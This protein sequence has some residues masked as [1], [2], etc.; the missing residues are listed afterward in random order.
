LLTEAQ[1]FLGSD[2][3]RGAALVREHVVGAAVITRFY[4]ANG[5]L[6]GSHTTN[7]SLGP[8]NVPTWKD[9]NGNIIEKKIPPAVQ[10][11]ARDLQTRLGGEYLVMVTRSPE[12]IYPPRYLVSVLYSPKVLREGQFRS[13]VIKINTNGSFVGVQETVF[14][15][16]KNVD[17]RLLY[18][19]LLQITSDPA[20]LLATGIKIRSAETNSITFDHKDYVWEIRRD[21]NG[22]VILEK[23]LPIVIQNVVDSLREQFGP[24]FGITVTA[25]KC[26][27]GEKC[28]GA[29][30]IQ[31]TYLPKV[32]RIGQLRSVSLT[33]GAKGD[34]RGVSNVHFDGMENL[35]G[36]MLYQALHQ[37]P[38]M[39]GRLPMQPLDP[40]VVHL[41]ALRTM[42][43]L[44]VNDVETN[45]AIHFQ[46]AGEAFRAYR[47]SDGKVILERELPLAVREYMN[48]LQTRLGDGFKVTAARQAD[49]SYLISVV[50]SKVY[51]KTPTEGLHQMRFVIRG[52]DLCTQGP[53]GKCTTTGCV[54]V[55]ES[56]QA[57]FYSPKGD[58]KVDGQ[59]LFEAMG[60]CPQGQVCTMHL[61]DD[62][63]KLAKLAR[64]AVSSVDPDGAIHFQL[65]GQNY[66]T[67]RDKNGN[68]VLEFENKL[69]PAVQAYIKNLQ[70][71]LGDGFSVTAL[72]QK[73]GTYQV[74]ILR[75]I[76]KP[77][78]GSFTSATF[79]LTS[80]GA[81]KTESIKVVYAGKEVDASLL[82]AGLQ[83]IPVIH[84]MIA[85]QVGSYCP[86]WNGLALLDRLSS[87]RIVETGKNLVRFDLDGQGY[88]AYRDVAGK[89]ILEK[90]LPLAVQAHVKDLQAQLGDGFIV[91]ATIQKD[92][93]YLI[94]VVDSKV[95]IRTPTAGL[96][97]MSYVLRE[98]SVCRQG[99]GG[100]CTSAGWSVDSKSLSAVYYAKGG[101]I[102]IKDSE[103]LFVAMG[104]CPQ[105][106]VCTVRVKGDLERLEKMSKITVSSVDSTGAIFYSL[107]GTYYKAYRD[108][109][110]NAR[111]IVIK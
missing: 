16:I 104:M 2:V 17:A 44:T 29:Y 106:Q 7:P 82:V 23:K 57:S 32:L 56:I 34:I 87:L 15:G 92:G 95:Y 50:D 77:T 24:A 93:T 46:L 83:Q 103:L 37:L 18:D 3:V 55:P 73:D 13:M 14:D 90:E 72:L 11:Y 52:L 30:S 35:D 110:G 101:D 68:V 45:G 67:F 60:A 85:C 25:I 49:G 48:D 41:Q 66:K 97:E 19:G 65:E 79:S 64:V 69:P 107:A 51:I 81:L 47:N 94:S 4:D 96:H 54:V 10:E 36:Q 39:D 75:N 105:G 109:A 80:Q 76:D 98:L 43:N 100:T 74:T 91:K 53:G 78:I 108:A 21:S 38:Y 22:K 71:R 59:L 62:T 12:K 42:A 70:A 63:E 99:P 88:K 9:A 20:Y 26:K 8:N 1:D 86:D 5:N 31:L 27:D 58:L 111:V 33:V 28:D 6:K 102:K 40:N 84:P 61:I 89:V